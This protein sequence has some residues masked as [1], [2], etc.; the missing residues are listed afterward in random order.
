MEDRAVV[1][2]RTVAG[3][4]VTFLG[5]YD[6]HG[7]SEVADLAAARL[8][9]D[10]FEALERGAE[11]AGALAAAYAETAGA[12]S[13]YIHVGSTACAVSLIGSRL[14]AGWLG[15][16]QL[17]VA[18]RDAV[19]L[20]TAAHRLD[21]AA[22]RA[23]VQSAGATFDGVYVMRGDRGLMVTRALGDR[24]FAPV[25]VT[26]APAFATLDLTGDE[27]YLLVLGTDGLWD[28]V[29]PEE[30]VALFSR[31]ASNVSFDYAR[32]LASAALTAG[33]GDNVTVVT[34]LIG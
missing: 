32:A 31:Q 5:V 11:P 18:T 4:L 24:W 17:V 15:D 10:F 26:A 6:G 21:D 16:S 9:G 23:R 19:R 34:A 29:D 8:H 28:V 1:L 14:T 33:T 30:V 20:V 25:G 12:A 2:Q 27:P 13:P 22:E 7:G 3:R